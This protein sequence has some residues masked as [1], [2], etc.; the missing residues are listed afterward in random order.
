MYKSLSL[1]LL[2]LAL[3]SC[4]TNNI[5]PKRS[6]SSDPIT[7]KQSET[8][9]ISIVDTY[10]EGP[11]NTPT[12]IGSMEQFELVFGKLKTTLRAD[13]RSYLQ[14]QQFFL[15][16]GESAFITRIPSQS[17]IGTKESQTGIYAQP[18]FNILLL[19]GLANLK[20][21]EAAPIRKAVLDLVKEKSAFL[22]IDPPAGLNTEGVLTWRNNSTDLLEQD[23]AALFYP[24][25][26]VNDPAFGKKGRYLEASGTVAGILSA[27]PYYIGPGGVV[28]KNVKA[29]EYK[30]TD[31]MITK[32]FH[33]ENGVAINPILEFD[34]G[35]LVG[36]ARTLKSNSEEVGNIPSRRVLSIIETSIGSILAPYIFAENNE[37]TWRT[38]KQQIEIYLTDVW[39]EG[40]IQG[41]D[42]ATAFNIEVG[43][44]TTMTPED[45]EANI[46]R[47]T[48]KIALN[49]YD[50]YVT[51]NYTQEVGQ[52]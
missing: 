51:L 16:G 41:A 15:N 26:L 35:I 3:F 30:L 10:S 52:K 27:N 44:G 13:N 18:F 11:L 37:M 46:M 39:K 48:V 14:V 50:K 19:P 5:S 24:R 23:R 22:L 38:A 31:S 32:M 47:V 6:L 28:F 21:P 4:S 17:E 9:I 7:S 8:N 20:E 1:L 36:G 43:L 45:V 2:S 34:A 33:P 12:P 25:L 49:R 42:P 40:A 29:L